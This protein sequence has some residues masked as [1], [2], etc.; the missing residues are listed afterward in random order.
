VEAYGYFRLQKALSYPDWAAVFWIEGQQ[1]ILI[2]LSS[3]SQGI[4]SNLSLLISSKSSFIY[5]YHC[6]PG[7]LGDVLL[8]ALG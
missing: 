5:G 3:F 8:L 1:T 7:Q 4:L 6:S 2:R